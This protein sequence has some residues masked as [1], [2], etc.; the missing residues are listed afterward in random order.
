ML[1]YTVIT[2][3]WLGELGFRAPS[4]K[5]HPAAL[6]PPAPAQGRNKLT[7]VPIGAARVVAATVNDVKRRH[8][9]NGQN[10]PK[11]GGRW[12]GQGGQE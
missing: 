12:G 11:E 3:L 10:G 5:S 7:T 1:N 4:L 9:K 6:P 2:F 8:K